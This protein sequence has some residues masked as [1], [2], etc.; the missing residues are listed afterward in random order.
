MN[1]ARGNTIELFMTIFVTEILFRI[2][3][4]RFP[5]V[6]FIIAQWPTTGVFRVFRVFR[7][8]RAFCLYKLKLVAGF[9]QSEADCNIDGRYLRFCLFGGII[10]EHSEILLLCSNDTFM[11]QLCS[12]QNKGGLVSFD[13]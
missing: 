6:D 5:P 10:L 4:M 9:I 8:L 2:Y 11:V 13:P 1:N 12:T 7:V 3:A